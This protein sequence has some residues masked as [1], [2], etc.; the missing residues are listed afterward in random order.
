MAS[1]LLPEHFADI[2]PRQ[3]RSLERIS[4]NTID[5]LTSYG[6]ELVEP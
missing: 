3:A 2:L 6:F 4:R 1:W 5:L